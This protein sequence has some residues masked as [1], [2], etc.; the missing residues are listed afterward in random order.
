MATDENYLDNLLKSL[1]ENEQQP[2]TM[3]DAMRDVAHTEKGKDSS[4]ESE[5]L[6]KDNSDI[7]FDDMDDWQSSLD[8]LLAQAD[9]QVKVSSDSDNSESIKNPENDESTEDVGMTIPESLANPEGAGSVDNSESTGNDDIWG[10]IDFLN[11]ED[12]MDA[13]LAEINGLLNNTDT[14]GNMEDDMLALLEGINDDYSGSNSQNDAFDIFADNAV[15]DLPGE[16]AGSVE[17]AENQPEEKTPKRK[18]FSRKKADK[19]KEDDNSKEKKE[20]KEKKK[21][22][23]APKQTETTEELNADNFPEELLNSEN[24]EKNQEKEEK[25]PGFFSRALEYLTREEEEPLDLDE[26]KADSLKEEQKK[27]KKEEKKRK[28]AEKKNKGK[29]DAAL[30]GE[31]EGDAEADTDKKKKKKEKKEKK[32]KKKK[33]KQAEGEGQ[34]KEKPVKILSRRNLLALVAVCATLTASICLLSTF[35]PEYADR[36]NARQAFYDGNYEDAYELLYDK[37]LSGS[38]ELIYNR[39]RIVLTIERKLNSYENNLAMGRE[40]EALDALIQGVNCYQELKGV[41][42]Y[43]VRA[44]VDGIYQQICSILQE[45]YDISREEALE[46]N[47]YDNATYTRKLHSVIDG[48]EFVMP[49]EEEPEEELPPQDILPEEEEIINF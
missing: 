35:L 14:S 2:R 44:E 23:K 10:D 29:A 26:E 40:L 18:L 16:S 36:Q 22:K 27:A 38:D 24:A 13:D 33:E 5:N 34:E 6:E 21:K 3:E 31:E 32:E 25:K 37:K 41:D 48:T 4:A 39:V 7:A 43:D 19:D 46:I 28:K 12:G 11:G 15:E 9:E 49:G 47:T 45:N 1:T 42:E 20:K 30:E 8:E 17:Q